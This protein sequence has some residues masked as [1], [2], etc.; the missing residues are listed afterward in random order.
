MFEGAT[1]ADAEVEDGLTRGDVHV[2]DTPG[3]PAL[4]EPAERNVI[5]H[6]MKII[7]IAGAGFLHGHERLLLRLLRWRSN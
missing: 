3:D 4:D 2:G 7:D 6:R 5:E 1:G